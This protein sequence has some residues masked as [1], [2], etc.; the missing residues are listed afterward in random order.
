MSKPL[1]HVTTRRA[2]VR[3][4]TRSVDFVLSTSLEDRAGDIV[5]Q[6]GWMLDRFKANP[7]VLWSHDHDVP[8]IGR[9]LNLRVEGDAL[10]GTVQFASAEQHPFAD[11]IF[12]LVQGGFINSG[13]VGF[14]AHRYEIRDKGLAFI[15]NELIEFSIC[16]V[17]MNPEALARA[18]SSG[19]DV[20]GLPNMRKVKSYSEVRDALFDDMAA[21]SQSARA[22]L[23]LARLRNR[24]K[25][26]RTKVR[27]IE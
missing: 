8:A 4:D 20:S 21:K 22:A 5:E 2:T 25:A 1:V 26:L 15:E 7:V 13:S 24:A 12:K 14:I 16:N 23:S 27:T 10:I 18:A 19:V 17:P 3:E 6:S 11:T 9:C